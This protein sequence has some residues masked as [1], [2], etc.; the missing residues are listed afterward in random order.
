MVNIT[1]MMNFFDKIR[2]KFFKNCFNVY[3][4]NN[5]I[6]KTKYPSFYSKL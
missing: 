6:I 2:P 5:D 3:I 4:I 1:K